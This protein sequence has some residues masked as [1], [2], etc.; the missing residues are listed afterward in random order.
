MMFLTESYAIVTKNPPPQRLMNSP[1]NPARKAPMMVIF[2]ITIRSCRTRRQ[3]KGSWRK[4]RAPRDVDLRV[5]KVR[6]RG[7]TLGSGRLATLLLPPS[8]NEYS[9]P[10][11]AGHEGPLS[12]MNLIANLKSVD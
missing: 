5:G 9:R 7:R 10:L 6:G 11:S 12:G 8:P 3:A 4:A 1:S 2:R